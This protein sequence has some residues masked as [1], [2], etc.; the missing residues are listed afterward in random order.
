MP[1]GILSDVPLPAAYRCRYFTD[2]SPF[3]R[4]TPRWTRPITEIRKTHENNFFQRPSAPFVDIR[5]LITEIRKTHK[6]NFFQR[7]SAPF[8]DI[9]WITAKLLPLAERRRRCKS[10]TPQWSVRNCGALTTCQGNSPSEMVK[11]SR[12]RCLGACDGTGF[13]SLC[14]AAVD[15]TYHRNTQNPRKKGFQR[16][17]APFVDIRCPINKTHKK[18]DFLRLLLS[19][20]RYA[21]RH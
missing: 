21:N 2:Y 5:C 10:I 12:C 11:L 19:F 17:S 13:L 6:N 1:D 20:N 3:D 8:V 14:H 4:R 7:P 15:S 9:K 16:P 18:K